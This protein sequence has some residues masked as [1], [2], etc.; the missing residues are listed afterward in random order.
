VILAQQLVQATI[1]TRTA[2]LCA[3]DETG[4]VVSI[5]GTGIQPLLTTVERAHG[6]MRRELEWGDWMVGKAAALLLLLMHPRAVFGAFMSVDAQAVLD[7]ARIPYTCD[8]TIPS[9]LNR[10][11]TGPCPM[12]MAVHG[13]EDPSAAL[14]TLKKV[15]GHMQSS[16]A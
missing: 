1:R 15:L 8:H 11:G 4:L 14:E 12:E 9:V 6:T 3:A 2:T 5:S 16:T 7:R 13:V 10:K